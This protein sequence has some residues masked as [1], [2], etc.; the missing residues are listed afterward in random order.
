VAFLPNL[1]P[2]T[3][4]LIEININMLLEAGLRY[5]ALGLLVLGT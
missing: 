5:Y 1:T 3:F 2:Y 4:A